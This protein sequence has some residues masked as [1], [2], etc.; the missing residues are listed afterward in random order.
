MLA[1]ARLLMRARCVEIEFDCRWERA[2]NLSCR[3]NAILVDPHLPGGLAEGKI[4]AYTLHMDGD[5]M[6]GHVKM[7]C[8]IGMGNSIGA[9][10]G[11]PVYVVDA[12]VEYDY[13]QH[14]GGQQLTN[15]ADINF[16]PPLAAIND[17]GLNFPLDKQ[18]AVIA[19]S[20]VGN[21]GNQALAITAAAAQMQAALAVVVPNQTPQ[22]QLAK[23][24]AA[25]KYMQQIGFQYDLERVSQYT[26]A[27]R[28]VEG[29]P[30]GA[31]YDIPVSNISIPLMIDLGA[32]S[33]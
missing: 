27:L 9:I 15:T 12:Y 5:T 3:K 32:P 14:I 28:A 30:F 18:Q 1:R 21:A 13:Q 11:T 26:L 8:A 16:S 6:I 19:N 22:D 24:I 25:A 33:V 20:L 7:A 31:E 4:V 23:Q 10:A 2:V 29:G 17:D